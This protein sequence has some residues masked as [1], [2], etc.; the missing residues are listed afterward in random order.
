M[1]TEDSPTEDSPPEVEERSINSKRVALHRVRSALPKTKKAR[2]ETLNDL[3]EAEVD[4][5]MSKVT[6]VINEDKSIKRK[7]ISRLGQHDRV[8]KLKVRRCL[9]ITKQSFYKMRK[10]NSFGSCKL[11]KEKKDHFDLVV[12][13]LK[14]NAQASSQKKHAS[15]GEARLYLRDQMNN[16]YRKFCNE[17]DDINVKKSFFYKCRGRHIKLA[18]TAKLNQCLCETCMNITLILK[19]LKKPFPN[20]P[21]SKSMLMEMMFCR[22]EGGSYKKVSMV[23]ALIVAQWNFLTHK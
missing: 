8:S 3:L 19:A 23:I 7:V 17:H 6:D 11:R 13:F 15:K 20:F 10:S 14:D 12:R 1:P 18:Q 5:S 16:L 22:V 21:Q 9:K 2:E 4:V